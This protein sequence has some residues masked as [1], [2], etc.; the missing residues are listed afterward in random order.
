MELE[1]GRI[2]LEIFIL[3]GAAKTLGWLLQK[4]GQPAV[5]GELLAGI[6][7]G[8]YVLRLAH[9]GPI[10]NVL[11]EIG[12][13]VLLF[14]AGLEQRLSELMRIGWVSTRVAVAGVALPF[15]LGFGAGLWFQHSNTESIFLGTALVATSVGITARVLREVGQQ[16]SLS[17]RIILAAAVIDDI[18]GMI[19]LAVV[20]GVSLGQKDARQVA[21]AVA[22]ALGLVTVVLVAGRRVVRQV[23]PR[24]AH[25]TREPTHFSLA[26][27][28]CLGLS[29]LSVEVGIAAIIGAFLAGLVF[30]EAEAAEELR[31]KTRA[32][33]EFVV[34]FFFVAM[35]MA[36]DI[37][38]FARKEILLT[39]GIVTLL[40]IFGKLV[41][42]GVAALNLGR[43]DAGRIGVGM[44]PRGEVGLIVALIGLNQKVMSAELYSVIVI[45][46]LV[47][48]MI[49]PP[50]LTCLYAKT[51][52]MPAETAVH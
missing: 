44:V 18:L 35:G 11:A 52:P 28:I 4:L 27:L 38:V 13:I 22:L 10:V 15:V 24:V 49:V 9:P 47:T 21:V 43:L 20:S 2:L 37:R 45:M 17:G 31:A 42:C 46:C 23:V 14:A 12:A 5:V 3:F 1:S 39:A 32:V 19:V 30:S 7:I 25:F 41:G 8:P 50:V 40:A 34:P 6:V 36:M 26:L 29:V 33:Y 51:K 16:Q 48:T